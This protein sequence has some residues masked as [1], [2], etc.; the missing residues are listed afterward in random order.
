MKLKDFLEDNDIRLEIFCEAERFTVMLQNCTI[1]ANIKGCFFSSTLVSSINGDNHI[2]CLQDVI[3]KIRGKVLYHKKK[4][5]K[6]P[7]CLKL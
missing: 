3:K 2:E 1:E 7:K 4:E 6:V 5:I